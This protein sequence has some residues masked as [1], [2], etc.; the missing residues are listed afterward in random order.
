[1]RAHSVPSPPTNPTPRQRSLRHRASRLPLRSAVRL[2]VHA[3][4]HFT[5]RAER[6]NALWS[7]SERV[8][9]GNQT[10]LNWA[11]RDAGIAVPWLVAEAADAPDSAEELHEAI[12]NELLACWAEQLASLPHKSTPQWL[13]LP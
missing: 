1:M 8:W 2:A 5:H 11:M 7:R 13:A 4:F 9:L 3:F 10:F 6:A 12:R